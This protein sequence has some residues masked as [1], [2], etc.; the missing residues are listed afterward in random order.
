MG[1]GTDFELTGVQTPQYVKA[2]KKESLLENKVS[3]YQ[4]YWLNVYMI[5]YT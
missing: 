5:R 2:S 1:E 3:A 4:C